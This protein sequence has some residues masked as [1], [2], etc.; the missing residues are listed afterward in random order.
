MTTTCKA[1]PQTDQKDLVEKFAKALAHYRV[2]QIE[3]LL[4]DGEYNYF[5]IDGEEIEEGDRA[6]YIEY[7]RRVCEPMR[8]TAEEPAT[9]EF[10]QCS[11]CKLGNPV[12]L[13]NGGKFPY[14]S[15]KF[16][17][18]QKWG[19]MLEF[20]EDLICG[21][22]YC[23]TFVK[24]ENPW[25]KG[26][27]VDYDRPEGVFEMENDMEDYEFSLRSKLDQP[28][29]FDPEQKSDNESDEISKG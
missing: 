7:L 28:I 9:I 13:L 19:M 5:D 23:A 25:N 27:I 16:Y 8:F 3:P 10:D 20:E 17:E 1:K 2:T 18:K 21:V 26:C 4:T 15:E 29:D 14:D 11:F 6:G 24:S 12:V 22:T